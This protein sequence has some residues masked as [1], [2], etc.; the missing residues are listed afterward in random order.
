[1]AHIRPHDPN[2]IPIGSWDTQP[3]FALHLLDEFSPRRFCHYDR[4]RLR[5]TRILHA[6]ELLQQLNILEFRCLKVTNSDG[7]HI[8]RFLIYAIANQ[9]LASGSVRFNWRYKR[10]QTPPSRLALEMVLLNMNVDPYIFEQ[11]L[12]VTAPD[13][14]P[15]PIFQENTTKRLIDI[16]LDMP[17]PRASDDPYMQQDAKTPSR[18]AARLLRRTLRQDSPKGMRTKLYGYQKNALWKLLRRE[19]CP[20][21]I[22]DSTFTPLKDVYG[23]TYYL[24]APNDSLTIRR[25]P[26]YTWDDV[27]GGIICEDM[28]TGKSCL[29]I[30]L[31]MQTLNRSSHP[32]VDTQV[33]C[34]LNPRAQSSTPM[35]QDDAHMEDSSTQ[36]P[37]LRS[38]AAAAVKKGCVD[39][40]RIQDYL[41]HG[42][43]E[44]LEE[45]LVYYYQAEANTANSRGSLPRAKQF[46]MVERP[47]KV[48]LSSTTLVI[49]PSN[50]ADQWCNE[51][52][53]HTEDHA[54]KLLRIESGLDQEIPDHKT[55]MKYDMVLIT[56]TR[57]AKEYEPGAYS[58]NHTRVNQGCSCSTL[59]V[60]CRCPVPRT[61]SPL[62]QVRWKRVIVDEGHSMGLKLSNHTLLAEQLHAD[63]RWICTGT[64]TFNLANMKPSS[65]SK[66]Q[67]SKSDKDDL[68]RLG[69][70]MQSFLHLQP[71]HDDKLL[72]SKTLVR[73]L[74]DHHR[75]KTR[76]SENWTLASLSSI[77]RLRYLMDRIM[78][79]N[80]PADVEKDVK[81]PPLYERIVRLDLDYYQVLT[82]NCLIATIQANAVLTE[83]VDVDY[84]FHP[85]NRKHLIRVIENLKDGCFWYPGGET[86]QQDLATTLRNVRNAIDRHQATPEGHYPR[87]D[88]DLLKEIYH[89]ISTALEDKD[90]SKLQKSQE[91]G[92]YCKNLTPA[93]QKKYALIPSPEAVN[94]LSQTERPSWNDSGGSSSSRDVTRPGGAQGSEGVCVMAAKDII[95]LRSNQKSRGARSTRRHQHHMGQADNLEES[96]SSASITGGGQSSSGS[97]DTTR[98][99][100]SKDAQ[101]ATD[102]RILSSTS[103]KLSYIIGQI[104]Q[105][106]DEKSIVFCQD[107]TSMYYVREYLTLAK[108]RCLMYHTHG[109]TER[110][111]STN[112]MTFNTSENV[113][114]IIMDTRHAAFGIDL[115]GASRVY[116]VSPVWQTATM[117]Q[118]IKRAHRIGQTRPV[119]VETL[120]IKDSFEEAILSRR[121]EIDKDEASGV[122]ESSAVASSSY[123][124]HENNRNKRRNRGPVKG[125][126]DDGKMRDFISNIAFMPLPRRIHDTTGIMEAKSSE[127]SVVYLSMND[128]L[129]FQSASQGRRASSEIPVVFPSNGA[130]T[131][132][133]DE[134]EVDNV[135]EEIQELEIGRIPVVDLDSD[136]DTDHDHDLLSERGSRII[137]IQDDDDDDEDDDDEHEVY[138]VDDDDDDEDDDHQPIDLDKLEMDMDMDHDHSRMFYETRKKLSG[139]SL[140]L[141]EKRPRDTE[142]FSS[143]ST[144]SRF[145]F[146]LDTMKDEVMDIIEV[147]TVKPKKEEEDDIKVLTK[148]ERDQYLWSR[149][150]KDEDKDTKGT[151]R[152]K[153]EAYDSKESIFPKLEAAKKEEEDDK[154]NIHARFK[155][156]DTKDGILPKSELD[157]V[158]PKFE[159]EDRKNG[160]FPKSEEPDSKHGIRLKFEPEDCK[161]GIRFKFE[162]DDSKEDLDMKIKMDNDDDDYGDDNYKRE[163]SLFGS[164][165]PEVDIHRHPALDDTKTTV[166]VKDEKKEYLKWDIID[167]DPHTLA[168]KVENNRTHLH[169]IKLERNGVLP[170]RSP[171]PGTFQDM[172]PIAESSKKR[173]RFG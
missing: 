121:N 148:E 24:H 89:Q 7:N 156:E 167:Y 94:N 82:I 77:S 164:V 166:N 104:L 81:L 144:T 39:Y 70:I 55:L 16:Y 131:Q 28:G 126:V 65:D 109:M 26:G 161:D 23:D 33:H 19:L 74:E 92:Y 18:S 8:S 141:D 49:V 142:S 97:S 34:E 120:V 169:P 86:Y 64:P 79:R 61:I 171:S 10:G 68:E 152:F 119:Y 98:H 12:V 165:K 11:E 116:F 32:P 66:S 114:A 47:T 37:S 90:W 38:L 51:V 4:P 110:E 75:I 63:H 99:G 41:N 106:Q 162:A 159:M 117:R 40:R 52:N 115:S 84:F 125:M 54:L 56:Q 130:T 103:T 129:A 91:V 140:K 22:L 111:R 139:L 143:C 30:A 122:A 78:V 88:F 149:V 3:N 43:L 133:E 57:F 105:N 29:C 9:S 168:P 155:R 2:L 100:P 158:F 113:S 80:K 160:I 46:K 118:A 136:L 87:E 69:T 20:E 35:P 137:V 44:L 21:P 173:V 76:G 15:T 25:R 13:Y 83:R 124:H 58:Q 108:V 95:S 93:L 145:V 172:E 132:S 1:M 6:L 123:N 53:K 102:A 17:S 138:D 112:I 96:E 14:H 42:S 67:P 48:F 36:F 73:S 107:V 31:I 45:H 146:N 128:Y 60:S 153:S 163:G 134:A 127:V 170:K 72:F 27:T 101:K 5:D 85:A 62:M 147:D 135:D 150:K 71:Y 157:S 59:Y 154:K 151:M 50:L